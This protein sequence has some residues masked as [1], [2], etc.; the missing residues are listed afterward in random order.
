MTIR[1]IKEIDDRDAHGHPQPNKLSLG[2]ARR[3]RNTATT[4]R[5]P[6]AALRRRSVMENLRSAMRT[7]G[8]QGNVPLIGVIVPL[9]RVS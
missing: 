2:R 4:T 5:N 3:A 8:D 7:T 6:D 9:A 1:A